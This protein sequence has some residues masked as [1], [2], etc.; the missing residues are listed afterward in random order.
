MKFITLFRV[1]ICLTLLATT[2]PALGQTV[3]RELTI[4]PYGMFIEGNAGRDVGCCSNG[5]QGVFMGDPDSGTGS[6]SFGFTVPADYAP[7][8][9][10]QVR[11][12]WSSDVASCD[13]GLRNNSL[14]RS[15]GGGAAVV[16]GFFPIITVLSAPANVQA[17]NTTT[18][19]FG[20]LGAIAAGD[21]ITA[22]FFRAG[23][24]GTLD[25]CNGNFHI[26]GVTVLYEGLTDAVFADRFESTN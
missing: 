11:F 20:D 12:I 1:L 13:I 22:G 24:G 9:P 15:P 21:A 3:A 19:N 7:G 26:L 17:T 6:F 4:N 8:T 2:L 25:T 14:Y 10:L 5:P 23:F 16:Q 18:V